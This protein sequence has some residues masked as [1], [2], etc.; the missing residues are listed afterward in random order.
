MYRNTID[1]FGNS[2]NQNKNW[3]HISTVLNSDMNIGLP[4]FKF[5]YKFI[6]ICLITLFS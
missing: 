6:S 3:E 2:K 4:K 1:N 5:I